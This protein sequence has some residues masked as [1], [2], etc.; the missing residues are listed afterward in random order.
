MKARDFF[1]T[2]IAKD[3]CL[4][5]ALILTGYSFNVQP[6]P[7]EIP[8]PQPKQSEAAVPAADTFQG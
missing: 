8:K 5:A 6:E 7:P 1:S 2:S 3:L 4:V